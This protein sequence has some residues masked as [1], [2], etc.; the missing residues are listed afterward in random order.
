MATGFDKNG[1]A[2]ETH[3]ATVSSFNP[4]TGEFKT[5]YEVRILAGTGIPA[6]STLTLAPVI[7]S[8]FTACWNGGEWV[9][10]TDLRGSTAYNKSDGAAQIIKSLGELDDSLTSLEPST[11]Y[12]QWDG[13]GWVTDTVALHASNV[14]EAERQKTSLRAVANAEIE[15]LQDAVDTGIAT[16]EEIALLAAWKTYRVQLMRIKTD[17]APD[18]EWPTLPEA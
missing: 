8:G 3:T 2:T 4:V 6:Y 16:D 5:T 10:V 9:E 11:P 13:A 14:A 17:T 1:N 15:W 18:I 12:D 7:Q